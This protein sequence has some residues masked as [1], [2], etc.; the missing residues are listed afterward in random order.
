MFPN[1]YIFNSP[2]TQCDTGNSQ[3][4]NEASQLIEI[5]EYLLWHR[6]LHQRRNHPQILKRLFLYICA[7]YIHIPG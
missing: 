3:I 6:P 1:V 7:S 5:I 2:S 4:L